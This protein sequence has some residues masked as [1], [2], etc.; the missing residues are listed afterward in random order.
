[1]REDLLALKLLSKKYKSIKLRNITSIQDRY[2]PHCRSLYISNT[3][4]GFGTEVSCS[5]CKPSKGNCHLCIWDMTEHRRCY[6]TKTYKNIL[7]AK[8]SKELWHAYKARAKF[9]DEVIKSFTQAKE[10]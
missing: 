5:V 8:T 1:M 10:K 6:E 4:T 7:K 3:L 9:I 2:P